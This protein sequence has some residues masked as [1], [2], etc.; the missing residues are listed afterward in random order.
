[1]IGWLTLVFRLVLAGLKSRR[2]LLL[3]NFALRHQL[4]VLTRGPIGHA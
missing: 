1:M 3:E 4:L 2:I